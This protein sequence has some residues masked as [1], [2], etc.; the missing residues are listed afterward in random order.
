M[1][2]TQKFIFGLFEMFYYLTQIFHDSS[3]DLQGSDRIH[4]FSLQRI[5]VNILSEIFFKHFQLTENRKNPVIPLFS[6][7][8]AKSRQLWLPILACHLVAFGKNKFKFHL[9]MAEAASF[10]VLPEGCRIGP[11]PLTSRQ[12]GRRRIVGF[13]Q[14]LSADS[15]MMCIYTQC[16]SPRQCKGKALLGL[17][18]GFVVYFRYFYRYIPKG[19]KTQLSTSLYCHIHCTG[20]N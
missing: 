19:E 9:P 3:I 20:R 10:P 12:S 8:S 6:E 18:G 5:I 17:T 4:A 11:L 7:V 13:V 14:G 16:V 1:S 15:G 2:V